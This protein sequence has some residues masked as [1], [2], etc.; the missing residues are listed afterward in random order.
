[1]K[2]ILKIFGA[3]WIVSGIAF[4]V[5]M[6]FTFKAKGFDESILKS[7]ADI[8]VDISDEYISFNPKTSSKNTI[9]FIQEH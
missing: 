2:K 5:Y 1:M 7:D 4:F 9:F 8:E 6:Y 3:V